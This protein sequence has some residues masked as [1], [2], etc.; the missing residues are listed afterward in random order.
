MALILP[1][2][3]VD[4][5]NETTIDNSHLRLTEKFLRPHFSSYTLDKKPEHIRLTEKY[6][7]LGP[8]IPMPKENMENIESLN[9]DLNNSVELPEFFEERNKTFLANPK[10]NQDDR[11]NSFENER[12]YVTSEEIIIPAPA[13]PEP[14]DFKPSDVLQNLK[15]LEETTKT[16]SE[17]LNNILAETPKDLE[18]KKAEETNSLDSGTPS[19]NEKVADISSEEIKD[20]NKDK[21][22]EADEILESAKNAIFSNDSFKD[23]NDSIE[24]S[25]I[26]GKSPD[27]F[28]RAKKT[29]G[30]A[31]IAALA[32]V[33]TSCVTFKDE[34]QTF[35]KAH[36][37]EWA[38]VWIK[39][40]LNKDKSS[41]LMS[42]GRLTPIEAVD[43]RRFYNNDKADAE[44]EISS[45]IEGQINNQDKSSEVMSV[46]RLAPVETLDVKKLKNNDAN[47]DTSAEEKPT[48][49][50]PNI[51]FI[52]QNKSNSRLNISDS[53]NETNRLGKE[54]N[55]THSVNEQEQ[56][57]K[58]AN[59]E[60]ENLLLGWETDK[61][62]KD[63]DNIKIMLES[64]DLEQKKQFLNI[65]GE[66]HTFEEYLNR[67]KEIMAIE[68]Y[69][70]RPW[71]KKA[72]GYISNKLSNALF[73]W[74]LFGGPSNAELLSYGVAAIVS[75]AA[76]GYSF[77]RIKINNRKIKKAEEALK[78][79][80]VNKAYEALKTR[81]YIDPN[82][83]D[84]DP[85]V[86]NFVRDLSDDIKEQMK[87]EGAKVAG[88]IVP[89]LEQANQNKLYL[90]SRISN[91]QNDLNNQQVQNEAL[92]QENAA[93]NQNNLYLQS[94]ISNL[95]NDLNNQQGQNAALQQE[96][97]AL[98]QNNLDL[99][100]RISNLQSDLNN[101]QGHNEVLQQQIADMQR[102][103]RYDKLAWEQMSAAERNALQKKIDDMQNQRDH[104]TIDSIS[105]KA[106]NEVERNVMSQFIKEDS[107]QLRH[108]NL[109]IEA[110]NQQTIKQ[111]EQIA[112]VE[113]EE[114]SRNIVDN[115]LQGAIESIKKNAGNNCDS[116][117]I[118]NSEIF[119]QSTR[120]IQSTET[121]TIPD[122][123]ESLASFV[124]GQSDATPDNGI[125]KI[126]ENIAYALQKAKSAIF[127]RD[128]SLEKLE[129]C[130]RRLEQSSAEE[131]A[132]TLIGKGRQ[133]FDCLE[134]QA[135]A[136]NIEVTVENKLALQK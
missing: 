61:N 28:F 134:D 43:I 106:V 21:P 75:I 114:L 18:T 105:R 2:T 92:Q 33:A 108:A 38:P 126:K 12:N 123:I 112:R 90:Q 122:N 81:K 77:L 1:I 16:G 132:E 22:L 115:T 50:D 46:G 133:A 131:I 68:A 13:V 57:E 102:Q 88:E 15:S 113:T 110:L 62:E 29:F 26:E 124:K 7:L 30:L 84:Y 127:S 67:S 96:N 14:S 8:N 103:H 31:A 89:K 40:Y 74:Q 116:Y 76:I 71:Y 120:S 6:L 36:C 73:I 66:C 20:S 91:L 130:E 5:L 111:Q 129:N 42:V 85:D 87:K 49:L 41:A 95:Q 53:T 34:I 4:A 25:H 104:E 59:D 23:G 79:N 101:K 35:M 128:K 55:E 109:N 97:A 98:N 44:N 100:S 93:L 52:P 17:H 58:D 60:I 69:A 54:C 80:V 70:N 117:S 47:T 86:A 78:T 83:P 3:T 37:P 135:K 19:V 10:S 45:E 119:S 48:I 51:S 56:A 107:E 82:Q 63:I 94:R 65:F 9:P 136:Q 32:A 11:F 72:Y 64:F 121:Q 99:Q 125:Q 27:V 118:G 24:K 39:K